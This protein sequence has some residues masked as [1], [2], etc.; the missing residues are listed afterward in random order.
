MWI[1][2][3]ASTSMKMPLYSYVPAGYPFVSV[4]INK[5]EIDINRFLVPQLISTFLVRVK[6]D[7]MLQKGI[8]DGDYVIVDRAVADP[9]EYDIV[10]ASVDNDQMFTIKTLRLDNHGKRYLESAN[11]DFEDIYPQE[12][13]EIL[14]K[15]I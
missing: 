6:G 8:V 1:S 5:K 11:P 9:L 15:V 3:D 7:S 4:D 14:G 13:L 12:S 2:V 10:I